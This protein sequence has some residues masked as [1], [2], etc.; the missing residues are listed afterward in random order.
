MT[1]GERYKQL[2]TDLEMAEALY[3]RWDTGEIVEYIIRDYG[4][5]SIEVL[6]ALY[7]RRNTGEIA[8]YI[9]RDYEEASIKVL[10]ALLDTH[11]ELWEKVNSLE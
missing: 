3:D 9:M 11:P 8:E 10:E 5:A 6:E 4:E 1:L 2:K 7:D